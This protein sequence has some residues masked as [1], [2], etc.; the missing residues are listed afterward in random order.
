MLNLFGSEYTA[1]KDFFESNII[2]SNYYG[3]E[4]PDVIDAASEVEE[5]VV[6]PETMQNLS[7]ASLQELQLQ[8]NPLERDTN[9]GISLYIRAQEI[10]FAA[11]LAIGEHEFFSLM[12][13]K[14]AKSLQTGC[15]D[16]AMWSTMLFSMMSFTAVYFGISTH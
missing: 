4:E 12:R 1:V 7:N 8:V 9:H 14:H 11:K 2:D 13:V 10:P 5:A 3:V 6:V 15:A 16:Q